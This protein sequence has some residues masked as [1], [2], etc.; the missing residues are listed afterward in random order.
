MAMGDL[1]LLEEELNPV[2]AK[3]RPSGFEITAVH[4]STRHE[5]IFVR[6]IFL[7]SAGVFVR[8]I[9]SI[10]T[11]S[12]HLY[13]EVAVKFVPVLEA[14]NDC[15][16]RAVNSN[17]NTINSYMLDS[18]CQCLAGE[19]DQAQF[20]ATGHRLFR[21]KVDGHPNRSRVKWKKAVEPDCRF[22]ANDAIRYALTREHYL[23]LKVRGK[24][25]T[26]VKPAPDLQKESTSE[27]PA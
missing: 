25:F 5:P 6:G 14:V 2:M 27:G 4:K 10:D 16:C 18:L 13:S 8:Y 3:L 21:F 9:T 12:Q 7:R 24:I 23:A 15:L 20:Q 26:C 22:Q 17:R 11:F 19:S 1:V